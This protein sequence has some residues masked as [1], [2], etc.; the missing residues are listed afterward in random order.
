MTLAAGTRL[1]PY[2]ILSPLGAGGMGEVYRA[3]DTRLERT[4]AIKVLPQHLSASPE[5]RQRFEREA[6]TISQLSHAHICALYDVGREGETEYLVMEY[7]EGETLSDRLA[8]GALPLEQTLRFG[9]EIADSLDKAHRQGIVHRDLKPG[10]VMITKSGVKLLDFGLA[11]AMAPVTRQT[12]LTSLPTVMGAG[13]NLTQEGTILGTFQ[14]M[15]PEQLEGR[16]ADA[17]TDLFAFGAL[18]Y[19]MATGKKAFSGAT[20]ASLIS[21]ILRDE[22]Q[23]ISQAQ[24]MSPAALDRVVKGC[25]AKDPEDRLQSA[26]DV[27]AQLKWIAESGSQAGVPAP[28][29]APRKT[30]RWFAW[31]AAV[32]L[33][34]LLVGVGF[35]LRR[36]APGLV[37]RTSLGLPTGVQLPGENQGL[38]LS[39]DGKH[40]AFAGTGRDGKRRLFVRAM[41]SLNAQPLEGT[42]GAMQPFWSPDDQFIAFFAD[43][44]LKR[45][46]LTGG[47]VQIVCDAA[48]PR[49]GAWGR[50]DVIVF[51]PNPFGGLQQVPAAGGTPETLTSPAKVITHRLPA[52]LPSGRVLFFQGMGLRSKENGIYCVDVATKKV[53]R[54]VP[55]ESGGVFASPGFLLFVRNGN[56]MAQQLDERTLRTA[57]SARILA[58]GV[59]YNPTRWTGNFGV[60]DTGLLVVQRGGTTA[61]SRLTWFDLDGNALGTLGEPA[62]FEEVAIS[63][64]GQRVAAT[65]LGPK[66]NVQLWLYDL[67]RG[68]ASRFVPGN[69]DS[70]QSSPVWSPD[71]RQIAFADFDGNICVKATDGLSETRVLLKVTSANS[72]PAAWSPDGTTLIIERQEA[73]TGWDI[74]KLP[75]DGA[76]KPTP[77]VATP[78]SEQLAGFS[79]DGKW[80]SY[81][82][83]ESGQFELYVVPYPGPGEKRPI[84]SGGASLGFWLGAGTEFVFQQ[85][86]KL[87]AVDAVASSPGKPRP[88][89]GGR[90]TPLRAIV[91][92]PD[93]KRLLMPVPIE[94]EASALLTVVAN[95]PQE[96]EKK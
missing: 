21:A 76:G 31:A 47:T 64:D 11:K 60:S 33:A 34:G 38:A 16:E 81:G 79:R 19:E 51:A 26:H 91:P 87:Y 66:G 83:T 95:W 39:H 54:V 20:Q 80:L 70:L 15:A 94:E 61:K 53:E 7:L 6:K 4:V 27:A 41:D 29:T 17:R 44:K 50:S 37:I 73:E 58:E 56:L 89:L 9:V 2:E 62:S 18:L 72:R 93:G 1:G 13:Q 40:L 43:Q 42:D 5:V 82:S 49:G 55:E 25:M 68:G 48:D 3:K 75:L 63:P 90:A 86:G 69:A 14:Y 46:P 67:V 57:G 22:P 59:W 35:W 92:S 84:S 28:A 71:S 52:F 23:P 12:G 24:P 88:L 30:R 36:P 10:N 96:L 74:W 77:L 45:V 85:D 32:P 65:V 8:K 78:A